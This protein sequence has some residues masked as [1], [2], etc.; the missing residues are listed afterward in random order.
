MKKRVTYPS[1]FTK[2]FSLTYDLFLLASCWFLIGFISLFIYN[3]LSG[4]D[5]FAN[6]IIGPLILLFTTLWYF[7]YFWS[8]G[9]RTLGM[10][11]WSHEIIKSDGSYLSAKDAF[12]RLLLNILFNVAG[13]AWMFFD[14]NKQTLTDKILKIQVIKRKRT[15]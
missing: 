13:L 5:N 8:E 12:Y 11:T 10:S 15:A 3:F 1:I 14:K 7:S 2:L 6:T 4:E 9:R